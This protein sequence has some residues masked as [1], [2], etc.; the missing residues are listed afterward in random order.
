MPTNTNA[1]DAMHFRSLSLENVRGFASSQSL[2]LVNEDGTVSLWNLIL[3]QNGVGKTTLLQALVG[4]RPFPA[5][6]EKSGD[7]AAPTLSTARISEFENEKIMRFIRRGGSGTT[8]M[9][10]M[11]ESSDG[12]ELKLAV[13]IRGSATELEKVAFLEDHYALRAEGPLV[14]HYGAGRYLGYRNLGGAADR[15]TTDS[16]FS[17]TI[18]LYDAEEIMEKVDYAAKIHDDRNDI[19]VKR[20]NALKEVAAS[21][22]PGPASTDIDV[23]GPRIE[24]RDSDLSGVHVRTPSGVMPLA[25]LSLGYQTMF[26]LSVNLAWRLFNAFPD[27]PEPLHESAIVLIDEVDLHLHPRWQRELARKLM[28]HFPRVQ[29]IATTHSPVFAQETLSQGG[30]VSVVGW[31]N[32]EAH[33]LNRPIPPGEWRYDQLLASD[34]FG[35]CSERS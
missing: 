32:D 35:F 27:S 14:I 11:L 4:M 15:E 3:G 30:N 26:A 1:P 2:N 19:E 18:E 10:A 25:E 23:R 9:T 33:I 17:E 12:K 6:V 20:F 16:P 31:A 34:L 13:E 5:T 21:I 7:A 8:T 29:F 22:L 24:G 28:A